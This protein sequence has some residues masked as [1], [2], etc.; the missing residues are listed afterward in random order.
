MGADYMD[1][2][3]RF[4]DEHRRDIVDP[5]SQRW[6]NEFCE[7]T[8]TS[9]TRAAVVWSQHGKTLTPLEAARRGGYEVG[10]RTALAPPEDAAEQSNRSPQGVSSQRRLTATEVAERDRMSAH[11]AP[12]AVDWAGPV[13]EYAEIDDLLEHP[14]AAT[15]QFPRIDPHI[16]VHDFGLVQSRTVGKKGAAALGWRVI[17]FARDENNLAHLRVR[18]EFTRLDDATEFLVL[19]RSNEALDAL[20]GQ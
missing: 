11:A 12:P 15:R 7:I 5:E 8:G 14:A 6:L 19:L 10:L 3:E 2:R 17:E 16:T 4:T 20:S 13:P 1:D 18:G 9:R